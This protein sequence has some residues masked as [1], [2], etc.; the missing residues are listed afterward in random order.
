MSKKYSELQE[1]LKDY[2][3]IPLGK[4]KDLTNVKINKLTFL[5]R[6][7]PHN[8]EQTAH[9]ACKCECG[10]SCVVRAT[11]VIQN[12]IKSCGCYAKEITPTANRIYEPNYEILTNRKFNLLT[13]KE[14]VGKDSANHA[15]WKCECECGNIVYVTAT[16]LKTGHTTSCGCA[17][18]SQYERRIDN[19]LKN[20]ELKYER[21][22]KFSELGKL[23]FDFK[24]YLKDKFILIEMQGQQHYKASSKF[25]GQEAFEVLQKND[26]K[27]VE[28][29]QKNNIQLIIIKYDEN[30]EEILQKNLL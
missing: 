2:K 6:I 10:T 30:I 29:C 16:H 15:I 26:K 3:V 27:K 28:F 23:R 25:G 7:Q 11:H 24:V 12:R 18:T 1:L 21:E 8:K 5:Y 4:A 20:N 9:W 13:A 14:Y 22:V 19:W 17:K